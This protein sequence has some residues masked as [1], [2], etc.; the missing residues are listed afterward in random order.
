[1]LT[2]TEFIF[3]LSFGLAL[4]MAITPVRLVSGG[5]YRNNLYVLLGLNV[6]ASLVAWFAPP[7]RPLPLWPP[8]AAA[9][10]SYLG[11]VI[12][13]YEWRLPGVLTLTLV[14]AAALAGAWLAAPL[15]E[16]VSPASRLLVWLD[17][18]AGGLVVGAT[19]AAMLLGHWY[20]NA[21]G[22]LLRP[23]RRLVALMGAAVALRALLCGV[24]LGLEVTASGPFDAG[25]WLAIALRWLAGIVAAGILAV[26]T[27]QTLKVPNTQS[28][29]G[30]LYVGVIATFL[31]ELTAQLLSGDSVHPL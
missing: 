29:T 31:G 30:I 28:A 8:L 10:L 3:R 18:A 12:W 2:L 22:M 1:M 23:L 26:M 19:V 4:S 20:L 15:A 9:I 11:A 13:L 24:G 6:L 16:T 7:E 17:P 25:R 21:P 5:Y 27:W 14:S